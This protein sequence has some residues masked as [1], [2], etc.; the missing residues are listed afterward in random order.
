MFFRACGA[1]E[2]TVT[3]L[4]RLRRKYLECKERKK[5]KKNKVLNL[6]S[7]MCFTLDNRLALHVQA[8]LQPVLT[9][10][11]IIRPK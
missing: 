3:L 4:R 5:E 11:E 7:F 9:C 1:S 2:Q 10:G 8:A 6:T